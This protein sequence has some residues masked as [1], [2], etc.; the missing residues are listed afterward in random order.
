MSLLSKILISCYQKSP[1]S[2]GTTF[3]SPQLLLSPLKNF[4]P[5]L[6]LCNSTGTT[7]SLSLL[8]FAISKVCWCPLCAFENKLRMIEQETLF[9]IEQACSETLI[10]VL[11]LLF[12]ACF[13][14]AISKTIKWAKHKSFKFAISIACFIRFFSFFSFW[15]LL[16]LFFVVVV[17]VVVVFFFFFF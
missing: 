12:I 10:F 2:T 9:V 6:E 4:F 13:I 15:L 11:K 17:V 1:I 8:F 16:L 5:I 7:L 14:F 3:F